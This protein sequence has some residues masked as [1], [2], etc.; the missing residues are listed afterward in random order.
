MTTE[1]P[2]PQARSWLP[3]LRSR[4]WTLL[5]GASLM[6]NL[7]VGGIIFGD[8]FAGGRMER[9]SGASYVQ[10][11]PRSF[12]HSLPRERRNQLM[13]IV[14]ESR[15]DLRGLR[16]QYEGT[17]LKLAEALEKEALSESDLREAV[18]AFSTGTESL[19]ARGGEVVVKIVGQLSPDERKALAQ[20]IRNREASGRKRR[21]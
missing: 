7:M 1:T 9:L 3:Q 18:T 8:R 2:N 19:A 5:L 21:N 10:L 13:Q 12:F 4:W 20:A 17:S 11:I 15:D 6:L 14:K 16:S